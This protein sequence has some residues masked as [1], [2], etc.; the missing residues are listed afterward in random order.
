M[1][2]QRLSKKRREELLS[3]AQKRFKRVCEAEHESRLLM[4]EDLRFSFGDQWDEQERQRR[5]REK[6]PCMTVDRL[7]DVVRKSTKQLRT[8]RPS[9]KIMP[10]GSDD[11][12]GAELLTDLIRSI[13]YNSGGAAPY[14][15]AAEFALRQGFGAFRVSSI[16]GDDP[17]TQS[18]RIKRITNPYTVYFDEGGECP[19]KSDARYCFVSSYLDQEAFEQRYPKARKESFERGNVGERLEDW[20]LDDKVRIAEYWTREMV[21]QTVLLLSDGRTVAESDLTTDDYQ[22]TIVKEGTAKVPRITRSVIT[23]SQVLE[24][25]YSW[26]GK[27]I[28]IIPVYG[29]EIVIEGKRS[30]RGL[31][32]TAKDPQKMLNV[33]RTTAAEINSQQPKAPWTLG[34]SQLSANAIES[35]SRANTHDQPYLVYNDEDNPNPPQR[36]PPPLA[37]QGITQEAMQ[38]EQDVQRATGIYDASLAAPSNE[39]SGRAILARQIAADDG[40]QVFADNLAASIEQAGRVLVDLIPTYYDTERVVRLVGED[41]AE[42]NEAVNVPELQWN[43][44]AIQTITKNDLTRGQYDVRAVTGPSYQTK[45]LEAADSMMQF[46]QLAPNAFP[47]VADLVAMTQDWPMAEKFAERLRNMV[48]PGVLDEEDPEKQAAQAQQAEQQMQ[49]EMMTLALAMEKA[50]LEN[51]KLR[52][53]IEETE[54]ATAEKEAKAEKLLVDMAN[55]R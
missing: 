26:P 48:P 52:Q 28:P 41:G 54:A 9:I 50:M 20:Y 14:I 34:E 4:L 55:G 10:E 51:E 40:L 24:G 46:V 37:S 3:A 32:R 49:R 17:W 33:A 23:G 7:G 21:E 35:F 36:Q 11:T 12:D 39:T 1:Q 47:L 18:L 44:S 31:I 8:N 19:V 29:E 42:R 53:E 6:R 27:Y 43:G 13:E 15:W 25:P 16:Q 22:L 5:K 38:Y 45:R 2:K 30:Y